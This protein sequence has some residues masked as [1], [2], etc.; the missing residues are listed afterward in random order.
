MPDRFWA[1]CIPEPNSGCWLW[2]GSTN[3]KGYGKLTTGLLASRLVAKNRHVRAHRVSYELL[4]SPIQSGLVL[5]HLCRTPCCVNPA[6]LEPVTNQENLLRGNGGK[7]W[8]AKTHCPQGHEYS[9]SNLQVRKHGRRGCK[10]CRSFGRGSKIVTL[11][12]ESKSL[13]EWSAITGLG[14]HTLNYRVRE[15]W[16]EER[17]LSAPRHPERTKR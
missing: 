7:H 6:H 16:P 8:A 10:A 13:R 11:R 15:G 14:I 1:N 5:D 2:I 4:V 12:G 3:E 9:G 17:I